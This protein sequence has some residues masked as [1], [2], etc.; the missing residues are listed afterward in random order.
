MM[1]L[2]SEVWADKIF[3]EIHTSSL[4]DS[5]DAWLISISPVLPKSSTRYFSE[6]SPLRK[7]YVQKALGH[8]IAVLGINTLVF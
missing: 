6:L 4:S 3:R 2:M 5:I 7:Y 1:S 8:K